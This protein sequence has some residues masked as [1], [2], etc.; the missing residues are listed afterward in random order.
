VSDHFLLSG[1][2]PAIIRPIQ[3]GDRPRVAKAFSL[4]SDETRQ[5]RFLAPKPRLT[6]SELRY[7]TQVDGCDHFALI[8]V[9]AEQPKW[10]LGVGRFVRDR[11]RADTAEFAIA[12][13]DPYQ[14][15]GLG[16]ELSRQLVDA[17]RARGIEHFTAWTLSDNVAAQRLIQSM[18]QSLTY[19][20]RGPG[21]REIVVDLAA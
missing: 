17:A 18:S 11:D 3:P 15:R 1:G 16:R 21:T 20:G 13:G 9:H 12:V 8:A 4:L 14:R 2:T 19:V 6:A 7:F 10:V 5:K